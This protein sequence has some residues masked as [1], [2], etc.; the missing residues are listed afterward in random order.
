MEMG[1][2]RTA[3]VFSAHPDDAEMAMGG[4]LIRLTRA[5]CRVV[6]VCLTQGEMGTFGDTA[7]R[8]LEFER[9]A[10][11]IGCEA[12]MLDFPDTGIENIRESR[13]RIARIIREVAPEIVFA[14]YHTNNLGE[15]GGIANVDHYSTGSLVR[16]A[17]KMA[18]LEKAVPDL[19]K[20]NIRKLYF[21]MLPRNVLPTLYVDVTESIDEAL[22]AISAYASQMSIQ[23][24]GTPITELLLTRRAAL[25]VE[26]GAKYA[27]GFVTDMPL[28][29]S[30]ESFFEL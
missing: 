6:H 11:I 12:R 16:D 17:V 18:R 27:E 30:A 24:K 15:L 4:T 2:P 22:R 1:Q 25:G 21:Y 10:E 26:I 3:L 5:G 9:A 29:L 14:P 13:I 7:A 28:V 19:P 23:F 8:R 20:H